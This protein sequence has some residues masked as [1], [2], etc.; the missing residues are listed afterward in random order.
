M[1]K[2]KDK[3]RAADRLRQQ[4]RRDEIKAKGVTDEGVTKGVTKGVTLEHAPPTDAAVITPE[5]WAEQVPANYGQAGCQCQHCRQLVAKKSKSFLNH[6]AYKPVSE[7]SSNEHNRVSLPGDV[8][9]TGGCLGSK[10]DSHR[11]G[12]YVGTWPVT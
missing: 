2:D 11:R 9:Y 12:P 1:Y 7:L 6:G 5:G 8:D 3:Q 10:Y 4:R